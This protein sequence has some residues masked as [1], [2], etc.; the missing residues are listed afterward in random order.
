MVILSYVTNKI[1][2]HSPWFLVESL[3]I[4]YQPVLLQIWLHIL[5]NQFRH[6]TSQDLEVLYTEEISILIL[7]KLYKQIPP[8]AHFLP[9]TIVQKQ[10][11]LSFFLNIA[12]VY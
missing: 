12:G 11:K 2:N 9:V 10:E 4:E 5:S 3:K 8:V 6:T 1:T 7:N